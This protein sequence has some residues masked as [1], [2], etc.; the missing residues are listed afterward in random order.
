MIGYRQ[1]ANFSTSKQKSMNDPISLDI[2]GDF[3]LSK[4]GLDVDAQYDCVQYSDSDHEQ[5]KDSFE[6]CE[7]SSDSLDPILLQEENILLGYPMMQ[8]FSRLV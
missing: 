5:E 7:Y 2:Y 4:L 3:S 1:P 6:F 8:R